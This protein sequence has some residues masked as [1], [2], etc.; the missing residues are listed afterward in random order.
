MESFYLF[1]AHAAKIQ[2]PLI[3]QQVFQ[4]ID[5]QRLE[6]VI[7]LGVAAAHVPHKIFM[8]LVLHAL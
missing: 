1:D 7:A 2:V 6:I 3:C 5:G 4:L 8:V